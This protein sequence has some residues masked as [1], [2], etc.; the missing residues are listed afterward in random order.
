MFLCLEGEIMIFVVVVNCCWDGGDEGDLGG[1][2]TTED[3]GIDFG[4]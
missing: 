1:V 2:R 4:V 3:G